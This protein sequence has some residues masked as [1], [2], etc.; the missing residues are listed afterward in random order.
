MNME[1]NGVSQGFIKYIHTYIY[2]C[3]YVYIVI[4]KKNSC[5]PP[6]PPFAT[7]Q[8]ESSPRY[9]KDQVVHE[10][11]ARDDTDEINICETFMEFEDFVIEDNPLQFEGNKALMC[12]YTMEEIKEIQDGDR[13]DATKTDETAHQKLAGDTSPG[14]NGRLHPQGDTP[15]IAEEQ[16]W[17]ETSSLFKPIETS[18]V[19]KTQIKLS[20]DVAKVFIKRTFYRFWYW[21][22]DLFEV[23][24]YK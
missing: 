2:M 18:E 17:S 4:K 22:A 16:P 15:V 5:S 6:P 7:T 23:Q 12:E 3:I 19:I 24:I 1:L 8:L 10:M 20:K 11:A 21:A 13:G 9:Y 14:Q